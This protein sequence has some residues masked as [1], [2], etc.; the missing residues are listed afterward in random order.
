M[1]LAHLSARLAAAALLSGL[2]ACTGAGGPGGAAGDEAQQPNLARET[3]D[4][5]RRLGT[6][7]DEYRL[8]VEPPP[9]GPLTTGRS[10][11]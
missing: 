1:T 9:R 10:E 3:S 6:P 7:P 11:Y 2:A 4:F 8:K 5:F